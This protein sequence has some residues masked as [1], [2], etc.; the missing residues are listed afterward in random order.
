V[1]P[2]I[3]AREQRLDLVVESLQQALLLR[4]RADDDD[5]VQQRRAYLLV[6]RVE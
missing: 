5:V 2:H 1:Q 6:D 4:R 3:R